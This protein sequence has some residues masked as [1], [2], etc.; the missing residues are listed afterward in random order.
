MGLSGAQRVAEPVVAAS[1]NAACAKY[2]RVFIEL[3]AGS[4]SRLGQPRERAI[5]C[6]TVRV[7]ADDDLTGVAGVQKVLDVITE[8]FDKPI[9][10]WVSIPCTW[11]FHMAAS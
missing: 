11:G 1:P 7:T 9:L 2:D 5:R 8:Y 4:Q 3:C 6:Y 10:I